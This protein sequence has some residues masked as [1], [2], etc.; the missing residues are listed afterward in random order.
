MSRPSSRP[1]EDYMNRPRQADGY[2][3]N[4]TTGSNDVFMLGQ[5]SRS[6]SRQQYERPGSRTGNYVDQPIQYYSQNTDLGYPR[7]Q[8]IIHQRQHS[9]QD[10]ISQRHY[11]AQDYSGRHFSSRGP[12]PVDDFYNRR[13]PA[14][15][16]TPVE[17]W[18][19]RDPQYQNR[20]LYGRQE[21]PPGGGYYGDNLFTYKDPV[22]PAVAGKRPVQSL[23]QP[24]S[25]KV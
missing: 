9:D 23:S 19:G 3:Q 16:Q 21:P 5:R 13:I 15:S 1:S 18:S 11:S 24:G 4:E 17:H 8:Q 6:S 22:Y 25:A 2:T 12:T 10:L 7:Q 14:R 20:Q